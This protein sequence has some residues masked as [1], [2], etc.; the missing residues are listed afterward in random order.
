[1]QVIKQITVFIFAGVFLLSS[2]GVLIYEIDCSCTGEQEVS[3]YVTPETCEDK[4]AHEHY[5]FHCYLNTGGENCDNC[6]AHNEDCGCESPEIK[7]VRLVNQFT[8][9]ETHYLKNEM[10]PVL[11]NSLSLLNC[12]LIYEVEDTCE[13]FYIDPPPLVASSFEYLI[14]INKLKIPELA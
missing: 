4:L 8:E 3:L 9:E 14:E 10:T 1:M 11:P 6:D 12:L 5:D 2:A 13:Q 7:Y